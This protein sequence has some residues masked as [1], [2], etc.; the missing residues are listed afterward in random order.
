[1]SELQFT[2]ILYSES[3]VCS[4]FRD[5]QLVK[6]DMHEEIEEGM[7]SIEERSSQTQDSNR[8][9]Y[10]EHDVSDSIDVDNECS[11]S[12]ILSISIS[13]ESNCFK[14][15]KLYTSNGIGLSR[16]SKGERRS[17][18]RGVCMM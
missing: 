4:C 12:S 17:I 18:Y 11:S 15:S 2:S 8:R 10:G 5:N 13:E 7:E 16:A 3:C 1:M 6:C 9:A 14:E